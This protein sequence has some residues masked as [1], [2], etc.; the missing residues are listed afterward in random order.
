MAQYE[1]D[2]RFDAF[3]GN[4]PYRAFRPS[5]NLYFDDFTGLPVT[6]MARRLS[7]ATQI[8]SGPAKPGSS[9]AQQADPTALP[10]DIQNQSELMHTMM[11]ELAT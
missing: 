11:V 5:I 1:A 8:P 3:N 2:P 7:F 4:L 9:Q 10:E 6:A